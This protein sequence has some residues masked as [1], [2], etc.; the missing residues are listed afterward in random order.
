M[1]IQ[2]AAV[3]EKLSLR[4]V[5]VDE[6]EEDVRKKRSKR[7]NFVDL[8]G[9]RRRDGG[10]CDGFRSDGRKCDGGGPD[11]GYGV[12]V[13]GRLDKKAINRAGGKASN[14][15]AESAL[16]AWEEEE[17]ENHFASGV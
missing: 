8:I 6:E 12:V 1:A 15:G 5:I 2:N 3:N 11:G 7:K 13:D 16:T 14:K 17:E 4:A 9:G 10:G